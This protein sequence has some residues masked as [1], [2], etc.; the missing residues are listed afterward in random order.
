MTM[1]TKPVAGKSNLLFRWASSF[2]RTSSSASICLI[3]Q[4][5]RIPAS[6]L[7]CRSFYHNNRI[8]LPSANGFKLLGRPEFAFGNLGR[9]SL[10]VSSGG[11]GGSGGKA[12]GGG[13]GGSG[14]GSSGGGGDGGINWSLLSWYMSLLAKYPVMTKAVTSAF[15]T[16]VGDLTCQLLIDQV[17]SLDLKRTFVF[18]LLGLVL[19]GPT[20]HFWYLSL[21][22]LVTAPGASG[23]FLRLL[24]DQF[25]F[26]PVFIGVF[27][28]TLMTLEGR[29][30]EVIPKL[31]QE[32]FSSVLANW[33]LWIPFQFINFRFVPQQ[34]Q[35]LAANFIAVIWNVILSYK[36]H[37]E[38]IAK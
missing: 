7:I 33:Q 26:A 36:A 6:N 10:R 25:L 2:P 4:S 15:L 35:V 1:F 8:S 5:S 28:S 11:G 19:V 31:Q 3:K 29:P 22:K 38:V 21:S 32:W 20:L 17:P 24:L 9:R 12:G 27:L 16:L 18:T 23:A 13:S 14:N 37:K 34:F 30:S